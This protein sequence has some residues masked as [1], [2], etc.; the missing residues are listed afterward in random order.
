MGRIGKNTPTK[1]S[2]LF[3]G[4]RKRLKAPQGTVVDAT[5]DVIQDLLGITLSP[6]LVSYTPQSRTL[7]IHAHGTIR[8]EIF[9]RRDEIL[10]HVRGRLGPQ[11]APTAII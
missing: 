3:E 2:D 9:L 10:V 8:N 7:R 4:Y 6:N 11:N 5:V 1:I